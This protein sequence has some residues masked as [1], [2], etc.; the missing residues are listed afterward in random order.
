M[1]SKLLLYFT[2]LLFIANAFGNSVYRIAVSELDAKGVPSDDA[3]I[4]TEFLRNDLYSTGKFSV[5][6]RSKMKEILEEIAFQQTGCTTAECAVEIGRILNVEKMIV[7]SVSK[8][9]NTYYVNIRFVDVQSG[10]I[11]FADKISCNCPIDILPVSVVDLANRI[12]KNAYLK[13]KTGDDIRDLSVTEGTGIFFIKSEPTGATVY[14]DGM[15]KG[16]SPIVLT[17]IPSGNHFIKINWSDGKEKEEF[18]E[19][20][21]SEVKRLNFLPDETTN[22]YG[23]KITIL[24]DPLESDV[25]VTGK[26][27][28]KTPL[29]LENIE[30][31]LHDLFL[32][33]ANAFAYDTIRVKKNQRETVRFNLVELPEVFHNTLYLDESYTKIYLNNKFLSELNEINSFKIKDYVDVNNF[34]NLISKALPNNNTINLTFVKDNSISIIPL[35]KLLASSTDKMNIEFKKLDIVIKSKNSNDKIYFNN[36]YLGR[37]AVTIQGTSDIERNDKLFL[38]DK[39]EILCINEDNANYMKKDFQH[40]DVIDFSDVAYGEVKFNISPVNYLIQIG[41]YTKVFNTKILQVIPDN[42]NFLIYTADYRKKIKNAE[43]EL[44]VEK[45]NSYKISHKF[46]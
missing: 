11:E 26:F 9:G 29:I 15:I 25:Y 10:V 27:R 2:L 6:E 8:L 42:Y 34:I 13:E 44:T 17:N 37:G 28:G 32:L 23:N 21:P 36:L 1:N 39:N 24:S 43:F 18:I 41:N 12:A 3:S 35:Y 20:L 40:Q 46:E 5:L 16:T 45:N 31:G 33:N 19:L 38:Y 14:L 4:I 7:G 22:I 30:P